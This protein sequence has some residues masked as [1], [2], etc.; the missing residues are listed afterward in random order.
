MRYTIKAA[1]FAVWMPALL[2]LLQLGACTKKDIMPEPVGEPVPYKDTAI[3][4]WKEMMEKP[5]YTL[6][7]A[8]WNRSDMNAIA[9]ADKAGAFLTVFMPSDQAFQAAGYT[10]EVINSASKETLDSL[11]SY[12]VVPGKYTPDNISHIK[13]S[14]QLKTLLTNDA[15][16]GYNTSQP[17]I[18]ILYAGYFHDSLV[19]NGANVAKWGTGQD[20]ADGYVYTTAVVLQKPMQTMWEYIESHPELSLFKAAIEMSDYEYSMGWSG[21]NNQML[22]MG[23]PGF[24]FTLFAPSNKAF[25]AAGFTTA[26]DIQNYINNS[27][28]V[29]DPDYDENWY[30]QNPTTAMD[31]ILFAHGLEAYL[32]AGQYYYPV[33]T[34]YF[35]N[36]LIQNAAGL[37]GVEIKPG[38]MYS[39]P[40]GI[41]HVDFSVVNGQLR[42]K[43]YKA[44]HTP[45]PLA[46]P[47]I[48]VLNGAI[49]VV[50]GLFMR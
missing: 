6:W 28:P 30:Y 17:Y 45:I 32:F 41:I 25:E 9:G 23:S 3:R 46:Q 47:N 10:M 22:L 31:S 49:H 37:S 40:P 2:V 34:T 14:A 50:D 16:M 4:S 33:S 11:L 42:V 13:G 29:K 19:I 12:Q 39:S 43:R 36:D 26:E 8:A 38:T 24:E 48:R 35:T 7:K 44:N 18:Y 21:M 15:V 20:A 1:A 27:L 5:G